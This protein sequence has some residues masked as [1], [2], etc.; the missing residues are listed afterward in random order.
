M[1][2]THTLVFTNKNAKPRVQVILCDYG[3]IPHIMLWYGAF[4]S[5]DKYTVRVDGY[6]VEMDEN[7]SPVSL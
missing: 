5:G 1:I 6:N 7:G 4:Y 2:E 3:S